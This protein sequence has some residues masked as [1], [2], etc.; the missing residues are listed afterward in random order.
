MKILVEYVP[1]Y[2]FGGDG[3]SVMRRFYLPSSNDPSI[4]GCDRPY[5]LL[6]SHEE[7]R[8]TRPFYCG[9]ATYGLGFWRCIKDVHVESSR[10]V[11]HNGKRSEMGPTVAEQCR[12]GAGPHSVSGR[13]PAGDPAGIRKN[14]GSWD[15]RR[16]GVSNSQGEDPAR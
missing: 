5:N 13:L 14:G 15:R 3:I 6:A 7:R 8:R 2:T 10:C 12:P 4:P 9:L 1:W 11:D 16:P